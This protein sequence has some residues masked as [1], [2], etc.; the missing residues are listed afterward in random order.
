MQTTLKVA[1]EQGYAIVAATG[2]SEL[3]IPIIRRDQVPIGALAIE[4]E[5]A[6][7]NLDVCL[8]IVRRLSELVSADPDGFRNVYDHLDPGTVTLRSAG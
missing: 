6:S 3:S 2:R 4:G 7:T 5:V 1:R 8:S